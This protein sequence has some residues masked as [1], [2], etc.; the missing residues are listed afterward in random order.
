MVEILFF[1]LLAV[2]VGIYLCIV[3]DQIIFDSTL[4]LVLM[5][6]SNVVIYFMALSAEIVILGFIITLASPVLPIYKVQMTKPPFLLPYL[7]FKV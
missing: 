1:I 5:I 6:A 2:I 4:L 7:T 3:S